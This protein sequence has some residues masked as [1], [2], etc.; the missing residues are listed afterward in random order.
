MHQIPLKPKALL[1][2]FRTHVCITRNQPRIP[3]S[4]FLGIQPSECQMYTEKTRNP[5]LTFTH[6]WAILP[7]VPGIDTIAASSPPTTAPR[8]L[9]TATISPP[10]VCLRSS[11]PAVSSVIL[12]ASAANLHPSLT[13]LLNGPSISSF[14]I[15]CSAPK[16]ISYFPLYLLMYFF[17]VLQAAPLSKV[18]LNSRASFFFSV[19]S[20]PF[21]CLHLCGF[22]SV[23]LLSF[24]WTFCCI[25]TITSVL[26]CCPSAAALTHSQLCPTSTRRKRHF[27]NF[28][29]VCLTVFL[30]SFSFSSSLLL[31]VKR[32][33]ILSLHFFHHLLLLYFTFFFFFFLFFF[34]HFSSFRFSWTRHLS[35]LLH[36]PFEV[37][38]SFPW[39]LPA[40]VLGASPWLFL[41]RVLGL[42]SSKLLGSLPWLFLF[43][44]SRVPPLTVSLFFFMPD[45]TRL[46]HP[47]SASYF[48][49]VIQRKIF[50]ETLGS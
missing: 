3:G 42:F 6:D 18:H 28:R 5:P 35:N 36:L 48:R 49:L 15:L 29:K 22:S 12:A 32:L 38:G 25:L 16:K 4:S 10:E 24:T 23:H 39:L 9:S 43:L 21:G 47:P 2:I 33:T 34:F 26:L 14:L 45:A 17:S 46:N 40:K 44:G 41:S 50:F 37:L 20:S 11:L 1:K 19:L 30:L 27:P 8:L 31:I 7:S 13:S